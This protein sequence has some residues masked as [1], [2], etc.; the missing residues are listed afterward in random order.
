MS[1]LQILI[2]CRIEWAAVGNCRCL[3]YFYGKRFVELVTSHSSVTESFWGV[4]E[5][6]FFSG[7]AIPKNEQHKYLLKAVVLMYNFGYF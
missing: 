6:C 5:N 7:G 2:M 1:M 4:N 3:I